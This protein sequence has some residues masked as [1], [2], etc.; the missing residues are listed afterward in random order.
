MAFNHVDKKDGLL[1]PKH[2]VEEQIAYMHSQSLI[3]LKMKNIIMAYFLYIF[4]LK[5]S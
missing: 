3:N 5:K 4:N 2:T 1:K